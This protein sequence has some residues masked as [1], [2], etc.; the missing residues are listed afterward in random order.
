MIYM[1][2]SLLYPIKTMMTF[3]LIIV[4]CIAYYDASTA[5]LRTHRY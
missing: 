1:P 3:L 2:T 5:P 4:C